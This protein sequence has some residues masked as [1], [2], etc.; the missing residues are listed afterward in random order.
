ME[1]FS[2]TPL[3][4][5]LNGVKT[6]KKIENISTTAEASPVVPNGYN[7]VEIM[8]E[9]NFNRLQELGAILA[10]GENLSEADREEYSDLNK[11]F[12]NAVETSSRVRVANTEK[13]EEHITK[14]RSQ[15]SMEHPIVFEMDDE[16]FERLQILSRLRKLLGSL[17]S[18]DE[19]EYTILN[20]EFHTL[21]N[22]ALRTSANTPPAPVIFES[23]VE[24][25]NELDTLKWNKGAEKFK[26]FIKIIQEQ[27]VREKFET[28]FNPIDLNALKALFLG[29]KPVV[30]LETP[31]DPDNLEIINLLKSFGI[32]VKGKYVYDKEQVGDVIKKHKEIFEIF[33]SDDPDT[34]MG[35]IGENKSA[36]GNHLA[37]GIL[38]G[39]PTESVKKYEYYENEK[40]NG[41]QPTKRQTINVYGIRWI[42]FDDSLESKIK[43]ARLKSAFELSGILSL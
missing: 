36:V 24:I 32:E 3:N 26:Q 12:I 41:I 38:L 43:Q 39:L 4:P 42:D 31:L 16:K 1:G 28:I 20:S 35:S 9:E 17:S 5:S 14:T 21:Y 10:M 34:I 15:D 23:P 11:K 7:S 25:F 19:Q 40:R 33:G 27:S 29:E 18:G 30:L 13:P 2:P 22:N 6:Q 8:G 37:V